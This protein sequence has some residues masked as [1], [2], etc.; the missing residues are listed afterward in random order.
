[1]IIVISCAVALV[2]ASGFLL[3]AGRF[4]RR[5]VIWIQEDIK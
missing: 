2:L 4:G 1:M 5:G 3:W